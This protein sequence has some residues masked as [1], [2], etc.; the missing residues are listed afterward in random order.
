[1]RATGNPCLPDLGL[2]SIVESI[3][4]D[5][6]SAPAPSYTVRCYAPELLHDDEFKKQARESALYLLCLWSS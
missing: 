5:N 1:M 4:Q 6:S 3:L 2:Y